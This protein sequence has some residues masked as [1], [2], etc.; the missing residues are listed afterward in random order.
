MQI[1]IS[2]IATSNNI[3]KLHS[4]LQPRF[5][6]VKLEPYT[7]EQFYEI[8]VQLLTSNNNNVDEETAKATADAV[9]NTSRNIRDSI[10]IGRMAKAVEDVDWLVTT[11]LR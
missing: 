8:T 3:E 5:F 4:V 2:V 1:E 6:V 10:K 11:F 9:W 7:Y